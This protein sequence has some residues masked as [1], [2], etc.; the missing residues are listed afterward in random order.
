MLITGATGFAGRH[1]SSYCL[2]QG[3]EVHALVRPGREGAVVPGVTAH[4]AALRDGP[5]VAAV[6]RDLGPDGVVHLA[7]ASS[8]GRSFAEPVAT[9]DVNLGGTLTLLEAARAT[10]VTGRVLVVTSGEI[11]GVV[12]VAE[13]PV[14]ERTPLNPVS[15]YGASKAAADLAAA[16]YRAA[17]GLAAVRLR[18]FN[19]VGPG[20]DPRF[21]LPNVARQIAR[22][23][24][25]G[26]P[27][28]VT[29]GNVETRRDFMDVRDMV[30][31]QLLLLEGGD[32]DAVY[33]ACT[34]RSVAVRELI[35]GLA[36]LARVPVTFRSDAGLRREGEQPDLYG[37]P[38]RLRAD[39]GWTPEI[40]MQTTLADTLEWWRRRVAEEE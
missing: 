31:A 36:A 37:S 32:P 4:A 21:V 20:Q 30:R 38:E 7:G 17:Y 33:L 10:G 18:A 34:G 29:V 8:V 2:A 22:A 23:E 3:H 6:L 5:G 1:L 27:V 39:T 16:Q 15:P 19:H 25:D 13:L 12:P 40:P 14:T 35:E 24:R 28:E 26:V 11:Y 9:W